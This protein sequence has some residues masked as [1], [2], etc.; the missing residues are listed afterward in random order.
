MIA[1]ATVPVLASFGAMFAA[2]QS[3]RRPASAP[4]DA[5]DVA[6]VGGAAK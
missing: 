6:A 5:I 2:W 1:F 4:W 3:R